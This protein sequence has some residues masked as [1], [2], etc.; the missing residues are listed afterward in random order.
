MSTRPPHR[1]AASIRVCAA[2]LLLAASCASD[3]VPGGTGPHFTGQRLEA[4]EPDAAS[5]GLEAATAPPSSTSA[6][7]LAEPAVP[8]APAEEPLPEEPPQPEEP[9]P[10]E[11]EP[12]PAEP[13]PQP[14]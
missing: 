10:E 5:T 9:Q 11:P 3:A 8:E 2:L 14:E 1:L 6:P 7:P 4:L 12:E 13:Q